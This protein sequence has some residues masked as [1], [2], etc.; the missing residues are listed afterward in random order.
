MPKEPRPDKKPVEKFGST[1]NLFI[2]EAKSKVAT[3]SVGKP[4]IYIYWV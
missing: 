3:G 4:F 1:S 2:F